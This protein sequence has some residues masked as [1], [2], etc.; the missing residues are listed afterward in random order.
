MSNEQID[1]LCLFGAGAHGRVVAHQARSIGVKDLCFADDALPTGSSIDETPVLFPDLESVSGYAMLITVGDIRTRQRIFD[2]SRASG[3]P[4]A[5]LIIE[6]ARFLSEDPGEGTMVLIG[7]FVNIGAK[8]GKNV[9]V[10]SGAIVEHDAIIDDHCHLAPGSVVGGAAKLGCGV[11]LGS[12][13]T[14][15]PGMSVCDWSTIGAGAV[16]CDHIK[17]PGTYIG[18][19]AKKFTDRDIRT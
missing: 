16:V 4:H 12:N 9:I 14:V 19:P 3:H 7:A 2:Q 11:L 18:V 5:R 13:A 6:G 8:I 1:K 15:L 10:N 17:E